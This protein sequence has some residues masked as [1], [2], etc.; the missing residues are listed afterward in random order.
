MSRIKEQINMDKN[1]KFEASRPSD[2]IKFE[3]KGVN[4]K[5]NETDDTKIINGRSVTSCCEGQ[6]KL[7]GRWYG[8]SASKCESGGGQAIT[9]K[10]RRI[11]R[12]VVR[13]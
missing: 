10:N 12:T 6:V 3:V 9:S 7:C 4:K 8:L 5:D 13:K 1:N 2:G 11:W